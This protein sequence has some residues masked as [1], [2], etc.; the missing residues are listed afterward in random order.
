MTPSTPSP[1]PRASHAAHDTLLIAALAADDLTA[2][3][4]SDA[5]A[6]RTACP[7]CAAL[8]ADLVAIA[9]AT[10]ALPAPARP[11]SFTLAPE[12]AA[13]LAPS[14]WRRLV[15]GIGNPTGFARPLAATFTTLGIAGLLLTALPAVGSFGFLASSGAALPAA[16]AGTND[17]SAEAQ[18][19]LA[20]P[21]SDQY[22]L[23][24]AGQS[25]APIAPGPKQPLA[26]PAA[27]GTGGG[28][29]GS[30]TVSG[31]IEPPASTKP[32]APAAGQGTPDEAIGSPSPAAAG[33]DGRTSTGSPSA[34]PVPPAE[35]A[36]TTT[37]SDGGRPWL[38]VLS[39]AL[40]GI[41]LGLF[42]ARRV[43]R[44]D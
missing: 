33:G 13:R 39:L 27:S 19:D 17:S 14:P 4:R 11:R 8:Y 5:E 32:G 25:S 18:R 40:L 35:I 2:A 28:G 23:D 26:S 44:S 7:E 24:A 43:G 22:G 29:K 30:G 38:L 1:D 15:A 34:E 21:T 31:A 36:T 16:T 10:K 37:T 9:A 41:G 3:A 42:A 20:S 6:R 12:Q